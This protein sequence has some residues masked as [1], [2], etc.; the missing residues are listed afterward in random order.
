MIPCLKSSK[1]TLYRWRVN[2]NRARKDFKLI[3]MKSK[4][5]WKDS[6]HFYSIR[7]HKFLKILK[8]QQDPQPF[9]CFIICTPAKATMKGKM[10]QIFPRTKA[11]WWSY[12]TVCSTNIGAYDK[13]VWNFKLRMQP[14]WANRERKRLLKIWRTWQRYSIAAYLTPLTNV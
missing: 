9:K 4:T 11:Q 14:T 2:R 10:T 7:N 5:M 12:P 3:T 6:L 8:F 13:K 1:S